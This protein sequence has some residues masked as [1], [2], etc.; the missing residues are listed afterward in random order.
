M[1]PRD[2][3]ASRSR[4]HEVHTDRL[5][6][7][8][9]ADADVDP[10]YS[11][12]GNREHMRFTHWAESRAHCEAWLRA[13]ADAR[14]INGFA[15][16]TIV[17]RAQARVIGWGGLNIDPNAPGWGPEV[18]Y[19]ID[20]ACQG[21]GFATELVRAALRHGFADHG[22]RQIGAFAMRENHASV[23]VLEKCGFRLLRYEPALERNHYEVRIEDWD[24]SRQ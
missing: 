16:W 8:E 21:K 22:L 19:F 23:R 15:P 6:L 7:R 2:T 3:C 17:H 20:A 13:Y 9:F 18:S 24:G 12:Q 10:L 14:R 5:I 11:I 4:M 1:P